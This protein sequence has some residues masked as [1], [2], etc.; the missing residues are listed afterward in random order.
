MDPNIRYSKQ[1]QLLVQVLPFLSKHPCFALKGGTAINLFV[2]NMPRLSVDI[3]LAFLPIADRNTSLSQIHQAMQNICDDLEQ[4]ADYHVSTSLL[5]ESKTIIRLVVGN[6]SSR[7]KIE[8]SPVLR[9][10]VHQPVVRTVTPV[11]ERQFGYA[12]AQILDFNDLYA[13]KLCAALDRQHPRDLY[14]VKLL[15]DNEGISEAL[16]NTFLVYLISHP[17]PIVELLA[18]NRQP[19]DGLFQKE[20]SGMTLEPVTLDALNDVREQLILEL[21]AR[22]T[23]QDRAFL[24]A[25]KQ[26]EPDWANFYYPEA[27]HLP[28]VRWKLH[29]IMKMNPSDRQEATRKLASTLRR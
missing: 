22:L 29:N 28:A 16:K 12:E 1:V 17:R 7:I 15:F 8:V 13:G 24:L 3:D 5:E 26:G 27:Q 6:G 25:V 20:L 2:R 19:L 21:H 9:G 23:D 10:S 11:V 18:P 14:D 4:Q